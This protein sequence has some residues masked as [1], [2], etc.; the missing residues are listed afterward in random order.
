MSLEGRVA[1]VTGSSGGG[2][3]R[4]TALSLAREGADVVLNYGTYSTE[5][6]PGLKVAAA[7]RDMGRKALL[8]KADTTRPADVKRMIARTAERFGR[9]DIL[10]NN[11][12][13]AWKEQPHDE[14]EP[15]FWRKVIDAELSGPFYCIRYALPIMRKRK[16]GRIVNIGWYEAEPWRKPPLDYSVGKAARHLLAEKL[17]P[18]EAKNG[19]TINNISPGEI[20]H[21]ELDEA[22]RAAKDPASRPNQRNASPSEIA[23]AVV[24]LC[25]DAAR[26]VSGGTIWVLGREATG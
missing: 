17:A 9:L 26:F 18:A 14:V 23:E 24:W 19:I 12:G 3:G 15:E 1:L 25:S 2:M 13:G 8:I 20:P 11:A 22:V 10:V 4:S 7:I 16:W 6:E 5:R 21:L